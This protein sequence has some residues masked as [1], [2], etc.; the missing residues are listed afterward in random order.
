MMKDE[1]L[2]MNL[3]LFGDTLERAREELRQMVEELDQLDQKA[4]DDEGLTEEEEK[5][6]DELLAKSEEARDK[7]Q[8]MEQ[9]K[10]RMQNIQGYAGSNQGDFDPRAANNPQD[11]HN[12][13]SRYSPR[14]IPQGADDPGE[15]RNLGEFLHCV[16]FRQNDPR[17]QDAYQDFEGRG[18][19]MSEGESGGFLVPAQFDQEIRQVDPG[20]TIVRPRATVIPAGSPPDASYTFPALNQSKSEGMHAGVEMT[21]I[22]EGEEKPETEPSFREVTLAP[23]EVAGHVEITDKLLRNWPAAN[24]F[25]TTIF[26]RAINAEEDYQFLRGNGVAKPYGF[27]NAGAAYVQSRDTGNEINYEDIVQMYS[28]VKMGGPLVWIGS[29]E[30]LPQLMNMEDT[31]NNLIWQPNAREGAPGTLIGIP[32][33]ISER[34]PSLGS[35]GDL[36]LVDLNYYMIKDGSGIFVAASEHVHFK[37]NKTVI[38]AFWNVDGQPWLTEPLKLENDYEVSPFVVLDA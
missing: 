11:N 33:L 32:F 10:S 18:M 31:A 34:T 27:I 2:R 38:K 22:G 30:L 8:Q 35:K 1:K 28:R 4:N 5:R 20:Q 23:K 7:I 16:R 17:L 15:F 26:R 25:L 13:S 14:Q 37:K 29:Q 9:R 6:F 12:Q 21:W 24:Q 3:Q 36:S 19:Q